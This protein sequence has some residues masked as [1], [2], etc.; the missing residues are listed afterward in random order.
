M[1]RDLATP[2]Y[3]QRDSRPCLACWCNLYLRAAHRTEPRITRIEHA[4]TNGVTRG[5]Y[6]QEVAFASA[7]SSMPHALDYRRRLP[8][9]CRQTP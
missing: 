1:N 7:C 2:A 5:S 6:K 3:H 9:N 4:D 8:P